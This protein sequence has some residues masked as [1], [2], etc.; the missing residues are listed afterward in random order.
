MHG[1]GRSLVAQA[2]QRSLITNRKQQRQCHMARRKAPSELQA[3]T[4]A[5]SVQ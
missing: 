5:H 2:P 1:K 4:L 3:A